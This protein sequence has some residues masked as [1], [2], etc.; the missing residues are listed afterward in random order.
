MRFKSFV[1]TRKMISVD[2]FYWNGTKKHKTYKRKMFPSTRGDNCTLGSAWALDPVLEWFAVRRNHRK[3]SMTPSSCYYIT[4]VV[5]CLFLLVSVLLVS[6]N[7]H[8]SSWHSLSVP[9]KGISWNRFKLHIS[10]STPKSIFHRRRC[11][12][13]TN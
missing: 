3:V 4:L 6:S 12:S 13:L 10:F 9:T 2:E 5:F 11:F 8:F 7:E 1:L